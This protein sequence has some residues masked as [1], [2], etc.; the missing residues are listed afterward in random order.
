MTEMQYQR[1]EAGT[2]EMP[3]SQGSNTLE[4]RYTV[5]LSFQLKA[6]LSGCKILKAVQGFL[7]FSVTYLESLGIFFLQV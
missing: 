6:S 4:V 2:P 3:D 5:A 7:M 1:E